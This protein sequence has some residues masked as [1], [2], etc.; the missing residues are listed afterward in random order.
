MT[1]LVGRR[2]DSGQAVRLTIADGRVSQADPAT[3]ADAAELWLGP[4]LV[5]LQINGFQ[6]QEF[7]DLQLTEE[8]VE[9]VSVALDA[10]GVTS[11][12]PTAT[13]HS[14]QMLENTMRV[15][16]A[17]RRN[18]PSVAAR[19]P[20]FHLE[21]PYLSPQDGPRGAHPLEHIRAPDW[22]EFQ[23]LQEAADG[24]IVLLTVSPEYDQAPEF[25][26]QAVNSGV[27]VSI[28][29]T[30][31]SSEQI[32][33][34]ADAGASS[35]THLG[36]GAHGV[37]PR[38]PNYLWDQLADDRLTACLIADGHH[39]PD[40]VLKTMVRAK[41]LERCVLVSDI[42]G[43]GGMPPGRY[44]S[45]SIGAVEVLEDGRLVVAGQR[46]YLA[47]AALPLRRGVVQVMR[48]AGLT[49]GEALPLATAAPARL[50]DAPLGG[51]EVGDRADLIQFR[52]PAEADAL[53]IVQLVRSCE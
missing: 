11:Y 41:S 24:G 33:A 46:Q 51:M 13:T 23:R 3:G 15:L 28:G 53:E 42:T 48:A 18:S 37:L 27:V 38:H 52:L 9:Q 49:L 30:A 2:F 8:K 32:R 16:A 35:S 7:N 36:N 50:I 1:E 29:H 45:T 10:D 44:E 12:L 25:I 43:L 20:G 47:G 21:G 34:A 14:F 22:D 5:D 4:G 40:A 17:A 6:G 39:L 31:A 19:A 26:R